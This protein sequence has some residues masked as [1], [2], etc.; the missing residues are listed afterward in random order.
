MGAVD[1][2][3]SPQDHSPKPQKAPLTPAATA[4]R[5]QSPRPSEQAIQFAIY[6]INVHLAAV[7]RALSL[8]VDPESG[9]AVA[10]ITDARTGEILQRIPTEDT[11]Q[12]ERMLARWSHGG[13]VLMDVEA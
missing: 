8:Q 4:V 9:H 6:R 1:D 13:N 2:Y 10:Q 3:G 11:A 12:L 5:D 7:D